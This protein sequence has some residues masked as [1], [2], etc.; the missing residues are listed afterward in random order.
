MALHNFPEGIAVGTTFSHDPLSKLWW[1]LSFLMAV[2]NIP[3]GL[4]V[5]TT[6]RLGQTGWAKIALALIL[7]EVPMCLGALCGGVLGIVP[8]PW[9]ASA[10]G[11]AGGAMLVLVGTELL[12]LARQLARGVSSLTGLAV[13][14]GMAW[15]LTI[16]L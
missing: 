6:L 1:K 2:H 16:F 5:A 8:I 10:L 15:L 9:T 3:E 12:P 7:A 14:I 13:G 4:A 11:F